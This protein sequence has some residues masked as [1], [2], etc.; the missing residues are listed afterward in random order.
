[1]DIDIVVPATN[2]ESGPSAVTVASVRPI[3][4]N[5]EEEGTNRRET[6]NRLNQCREEGCDVTIIWILD[7]DPHLNKQAQNEQS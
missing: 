6:E 2:G 3:V 5:G 4:V 1:M 7:N